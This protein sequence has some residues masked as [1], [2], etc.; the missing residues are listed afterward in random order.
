A[1]V[2]LS[3]FLVVEVA[4]FASQFSHRVEERNLFY[5]APL[6]LIALLAWIERGQPKPSRAAVVAAGL[7]AALP[8]MIPFLSLLDITAQSDTLGFQPWWFVG[9]AWAGLDSVS[10]VAVAV[11]TA[12]A[13]AF[14]WLPRRHAPALTALVAVGFLL[15]WL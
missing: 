4:V 6:F 12:L 3:V 13:A 11:S 1:A 7:A 2:S 15:T 8:G 9:D 5:L 14:L 10:L